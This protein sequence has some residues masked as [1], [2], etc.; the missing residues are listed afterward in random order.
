MVS[1]SFLSADGGYVPSLKYCRMSEYHSPS[2]FFPLSSYF[3]STT[4]G[5]VSS[6]L[7]PFIMDAIVAKA[8]TV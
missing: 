6:S 1:W 3:C 8:F 5:L 4:I 2:P 7:G